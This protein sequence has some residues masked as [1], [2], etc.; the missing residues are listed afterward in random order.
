M[1]NSYFSLA[2]TI[3]SYYRPGMAY[4]QTME[5]A[6]REAGG[7]TGL[8]ERVGRPVTTVSSWRHS[9]FPSKD[10]FV[11]GAMF[12][13]LGHTLSPALFG[14]SEPEEGFPQEPERASA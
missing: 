8:A 14:M 1:I 11:I 3:Y 9:T 7:T 2:D 6:F 12:E 4:L 10:F 5:E 13:A